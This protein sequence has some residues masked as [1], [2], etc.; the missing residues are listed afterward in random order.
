MGSHSRFIT[1]KQQYI[2]MCRSELPVSLAVAV[3]VV[4]LYLHAQCQ[5]IALPGIQRPGAAGR[6]LG[7]GRYAQ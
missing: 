3:C 2:R 5:I 7:A 6:T 4:N 1:W